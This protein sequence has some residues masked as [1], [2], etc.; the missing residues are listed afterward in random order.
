MPYCDMHGDFEGRHCPDCHHE[1]LGAAAKSGIDRDELRELVRAVSQDRIDANSLAVTLADKLNNP[2]HFVCPSCKLRTLQ[3]GATRC[4]R[5]QGVNGI[6][7]E[8]VRWTD[9]KC[10]AEM[11]ALEAH[12]KYREWVQRKRR[13]YF[14]R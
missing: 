11:E 14:G 3:F 6:D 12:P 13:E 7:W 5:C 1:L 10:I 2:G 8:E 9:P 4:P